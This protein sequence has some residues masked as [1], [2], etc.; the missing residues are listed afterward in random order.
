MNIDTLNTQL[1]DLAAAGEFSGVVR[2]DGPDGTLLEAGYGMASHTWQ[3]P[4]TPETRFDTASITKLF[5]AVAV[6]QQV[7]QGAFTLDTS[8]VDHLG[9]EGTAISPQATVHHMLSHTSGI[10]DDADEEAGEDY[11]AVYADR[12]SYSV[13]RTADL[14]VG[15]Q[16]K[17]AN[18]APGAGCR[19]CNASYVLLGLMVEKASGQPY[20]DYVVEKVFG[21]AG[22]ERSGFFAM[23]R[24][25]PQVAEGVEPV[26]EVPELRRN[27]Y[28]YPP[29]GS[30]D[31][32]AHV[33]AGDLVAFH[34]ALL[35]G[36]LLSVESVRAM[37]GQQAEHVDEDGDAHWM[38]YGWESGAPDDSGEVRSYWKDGVNVG[39]SGVIRHYPRH[40][41]TV[42]VLS[43]LTDGAWEPMSLADDL[44][45]QL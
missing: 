34:R 30:P 39:A 6:L 27:I 25:V 19:Y 18:F 42:V 44:V 20:R 35:D 41:V 29:V 32:G 37:L 22:M 26:D 17:P 8:V 14:L 3:V 9:L 23:D 5:T 31:G 38:G 43:N 15:F 40:G 4:A 24:V 7:E 2:I 45:D 36:R 13:R 33:T 11:E 21:P 10:G 16:D 1:T 12:P 28:S